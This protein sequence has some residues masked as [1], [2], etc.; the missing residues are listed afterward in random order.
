M[1]INYVD[2]NVD[3]IQNFFIDFEFLNFTILDQEK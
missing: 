1:A 3:Q 2:I